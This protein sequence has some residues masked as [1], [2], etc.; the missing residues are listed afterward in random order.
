MNNN[1]G[2]GNDSFTTDNP[3]ILTE[4]LAQNS[5]SGIVDSSELKCG[6]IMWQEFYYN[7]WIYIDASI[8]SLVP[9]TL[10]IIFNFLIIKYLFKASNE[11]SMLKEEGK[12]FMR[13]YKS[14][15]KGY[16]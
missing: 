16:F 9:S 13:I 8:Y 5:S 6:H 1:D 2:L 3:S 15:T 10:L 11:S 14:T 4:E 7:Y 12:S